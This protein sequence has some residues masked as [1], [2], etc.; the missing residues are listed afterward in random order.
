MATGPLG[1]RTPTDFTHVE[2]YPLTALAEP[3]QPTAVPVAIGINWYTNFDSPQQEG[4]RWWIGRGDL[5]TIRGGHCVCL[6]PGKVPDHTSWWEFYDQGKEGA[7]V[8]FGCS[9]V[10]SLL[11]RKRYFARWLWDHAKM[12][13]EWPDTNPGDDQGTAVRAAMDVLRGVG[14]VSWKASYAQLDVPQRDAVPGVASE[15]IAANRWATT[16]DEVHR[17]LATPLA[18]QLGAVPFVNSWG[19]A[20]PHITWMPDETL[21]RLIQEDGEVALVTDR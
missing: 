20:Y 12:G 5:G 6:K 14:H 21:D 8:G 17:T 10:M 19:R 2:K 9:R 15:G 1:R 18:D 11:N 13:D 7:C 4:N 16:V 3:A